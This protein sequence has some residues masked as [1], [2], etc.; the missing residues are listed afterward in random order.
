M[1]PEQQ[2]EQLDYG[3]LEKLILETEASQVETLYL[4]RR[5][6]RIQPF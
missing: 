4:G 5:A 6:A 3:L 1:T 2:R